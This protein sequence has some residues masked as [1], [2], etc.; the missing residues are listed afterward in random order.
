M[1]P[2]AA[3]YMTLV[4]GSALYAPWALFTSAFVETSIFE[5]GNNISSDFQSFSYVVTIVHCIDSLRPGCSEL[6]GAPMGKH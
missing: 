4:P 1:A 2:E 5:V 6:P 3:R